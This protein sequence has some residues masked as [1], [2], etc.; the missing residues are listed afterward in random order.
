MRRIFLVA[1]VVLMAGCGGSTNDGGTTDAG[2]GGTGGSGAGGSG[3][4][5]G[6]TGGS[7]G[8]TG[9]SGGQGATGGQA[10]TGPVAGEC[11]T[12]ADCAL[13]SSCCDCVAGPKG[14][15]QLPSCQI[16][17]C[18][19][20]ECTSRQIDQARCIAGQC[21]LGYDCDGSKVFC[22]AIP[23][24]CPAGQLPRV[25][26]GCWGECVPMTQCASVP[27]C[28]SC[29][30]GTACVVYDAQLSTHH[31][32]TPAQGCAADCS[33]LGQTLCTGGFDI[34][35]EFDDGSAIHCSCPAC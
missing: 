34:C 9:G 12:D 19:V 11:T 35:G 23:P 4:G 13:G 30:S 10:G 3:G 17:E 32:V 2:V 29:P 7:G 8:A 28:F 14:K 18:L 16:Q 22:N 6:A 25:V 1:A 15:V 33:C 27:D 20:D 24:T 21:I 31:C 26:G 5:Q